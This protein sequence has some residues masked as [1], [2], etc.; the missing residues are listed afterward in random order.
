MLGILAAMEIEL[1]E[2]TEALDHVEEFHHGGRVFY[3]GKLEGIP[4]VLAVTGVGKVNAAM[5]A[6]CMIDF[7]SPKALIHT[8]IAG[9]LREGLKVGDLVLS[10]GAAE[11]DADLSAIGYPLGVMPGFP[12]REVR[13]DEELLRFA[14]EAAESLHL[15]GEVSEGLVL[16][17]DVF[18][19]SS[20][21]KRFLQEE[22][23]GD[24]VEMEGAATAK[25]AR[26]NGLPWLIIRSVSDGGDDD[27][28]K[29]YDA[30]EAFAAE[31]E[32]LLLK[33]L[34]K[35]RELRERWI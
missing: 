23:K 11:H 3:K 4:V 17:G 26:Q 21:R 7:F 29:N 24:V 6:Q 28:Y 12:E 15:P 20:E 30:F 22:F 25:V 33:E 35:H 31:R 32:L 1:K 5:T 13:A 14:K 27:A 16:T 8:G 19:S 34:L 9:G 10:S 2:L 18:L